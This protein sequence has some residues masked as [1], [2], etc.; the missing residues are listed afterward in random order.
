MVY[1]NKTYVAFDGD[2]DINYY[3]A[4]Q[5][6]R[7]SDNNK[8]NFYDSH[9]LNNALDS[10]SEET[11]KRKLRER[12]VNSKTFVLLIGEGTR[13]LYK[14]VRWE[15]EQAINLD[16][17]IVIVNLPKT[18]E[19][20][21]KRNIDYERC[22]K[23]AKDTLAVHISFRAKILQFALENW[24]N[25]HESYSQRGENEPYYYKNSV[26]QKLGL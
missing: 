26:Y 4:M 12:L 19:S 25:S 2:N 17:P 22:P 11:I 18:F 14:F 13:Y 15:I 10:S 1:R 7:K 5:M 9:D 24:P 23:M 16:L 6:W 21:G 3:R 20:E 8:F